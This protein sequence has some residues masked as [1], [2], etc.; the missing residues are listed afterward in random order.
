[1]SRNL[2][3]L[4]ERAARDGRS[5]IDLL[6]SARRDGAITGETIDR[7]ARES[8]LPAQHLRAVAESYDELNPSAAPTPS[9]KVCNGEACRAA[10]GDRVAESL[11]DRAGEVT[12]LG[13]CSHGPNVALDGRVVTIDSDET[14]ARIKRGDGA[15][16]EEP[17]NPIHPPAHGTPSILLAAMNRPHTGYPAYDKA[18]ALG[19]ERLRAEID[20][21]QLRGRGG[22]G[23]PI[24]RKLATTAAAPSADGRRFVVANLDEGDAGA[25]IDKELAERSPHRLIE[26]IQIAAL[27]CGASE[28]YLYIR[29]E[30]PKSWAVLSET[31]KGAPGV[32]IHL[33]RGHGAYVCGEETSLLRA[34]EGLPGEVSTRP[35]YPAERGLFERPTAVNNVETLCN[36]PWIVEHGGDAFAAIGVAGSSGTKLVS[37]NNRVKRPGLYEVAMGT[38]LR[39]IIFGH[40]G[41]MADGHRFQGVQV[42]GPLGAILPD[43]LL[44]TPLAFEPM[45]GAGATLGH[46]GMVV[47]SDQDDLLDIARGLMAFCARESC[48]KCFPCRIG[49]TRGV[50]LIDRIR[51]DGLS[52]ERRTLLDDLC[53][54]LRLGSLCGLGG[55]APV[56]VESLL[57]FFPDIWPT[58]GGAGK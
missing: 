2:I 42:G 31:V 50:E 4:R 49:T 7:L 22:A 3:A 48:G 12:C 51:A 23:F 25:Y 18:R 30:Y 6:E 37:L 14:L 58:S 11:G 40:A 38:P 27:A 1:M 55:M 45:S 53:E 24:A 20:A 10:G 56:P 57:R 44:D 15:T 21:S 8:H 52:G 17:E 34:I 5:A 13:L 33:V 41:G 32:P 54:T 46:A 39:E 43:S 9:I 16:L 28:A 36:L 35:P 26:G 29:H 19:A 47:F